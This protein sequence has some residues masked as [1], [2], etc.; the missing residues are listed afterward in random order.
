MNCVEVPSNPPDQEYRDLIVRELDKTMLVEAAAGTGKTTSMLNRMVALLET[1]RCKIDSLA[2]VTFTRKAASEIRSRFQVR[3]ET[4]V[5]ESKGNARG[6]LADALEHIDRCSIGTIHAFCA[7][8]LRERPIEAGVD[9]G[10]EE[11]DEDADARLRQDAWRE[12]VDSL[13]AAD[14]PILSELEDVGL[15]ISRTTKWRGRSRGGIGRG[16]LRRSAT[17]PGLY[18]SGR[19]SRCR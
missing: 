7:R 15:K 2:A 19:L 14:G 11:I 8:L 13:M 4:A 10:F 6:R 16:R 5:R 1:G 17:W 9:I 12:Y 18:A 3:L